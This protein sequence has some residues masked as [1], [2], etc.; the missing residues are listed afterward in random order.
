MIIRSPNTRGHLKSDWI[1][2]RRTF[3][4]NSYWDPK[5]MNF[6]PI[7]VIN[8]DILQPGYMVPKHEHKNMEILGYMVDGQLEHWD[9]EGNL[10][11]ATVGQIQHMSCG[12]SIWHTEKCIS[13]TPAR[14]LQIWISPT[15]SNTYPFYEI[16]T[17]SLDFGPVLIG[18]QETIINAGI[19]QQHY[20]VEVS[21]KAYLYV[22]S[23]NISNNDIQLSEGFGMELE[24]EFFEANFES[25]II[26]IEF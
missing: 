11:I 22:V 1:E 12:E 4:N 10:N 26:L 19:I 18:N 14:Y 25:H 13:N 24:S 3:S 15:K 20:K 21:G 23:G 8:D 16:I 9:S 2:S 7:Q 6:G 17:K 5:Y